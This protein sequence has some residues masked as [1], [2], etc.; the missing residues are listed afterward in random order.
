V[1]EFLI[2]DTQ[3]PRS[4]IRCLQACQ[5][6]AH[7]ISDPALDLPGN[8]VEHELAGLLAWLRNRDIQEVVRDG[9]HES[10]THVVNTIHDIGETIKKTYFDV[11]LQPL[12]SVEASVA[13]GI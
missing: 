13:S 1:A 6:A 4:V 11:R 8:S 5:N 7:A 9:L 3:F 2:F 10:L 12:P